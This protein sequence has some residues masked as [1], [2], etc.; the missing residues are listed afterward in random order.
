MSKVYLVTRGEYDGYVICA[1]F[2]TEEKAQQ[3]IDKGWYRSL[4]ESRSYGCARV[5]EFEIDPTQ[6]PKE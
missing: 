6:S 3:A 5:E 2:S 1:A 4:F